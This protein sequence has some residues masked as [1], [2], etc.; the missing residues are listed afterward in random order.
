MKLI[1]GEKPWPTLDRITEDEKLYFSGIIKCY[2]ESMNELLYKNPLIVDNNIQKIYEIQCMKK[3][4]SFDHIIVG[5][6][7]GS[8]SEKTYVDSSFILS[9]QIY[10]QQPITKLNFP[11]PYGLIKDEK[12]TDLFKKILRAGRSSRC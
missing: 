11:T 6:C 12:Y 1:P 4:F 5:N 7:D 8:F 9:K 10:G 2:Y 3:Q